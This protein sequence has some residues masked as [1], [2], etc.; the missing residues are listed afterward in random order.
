MTPPQ[1]PL[2][3]NAVP[4]LPEELLHGFAP[5]NVRTALRSVMEPDGAEPTAA[6]L[7]EAVYEIPQYDGNLLLLPGVYNWGMLESDLAAVV[8]TG[9]QD[10]Q[11]TW[12]DRTNRYVGAIRWMLNKI[13]AHLSIDYVLID[14][15]PANNAVNKFFAMS[16]DF[17]LPPVFPDF[18]S[19]N[20]VQGLLHEVLPGWYQWREQVRV[21]E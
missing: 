20:S 7:C 8:A 17:I 2:N 11:P 19:M 13:M 12:H 15:A 16:S 4:A 14:C 10:G 9:G 18:F 5:V 6:D 21:T 3:R 1:Y